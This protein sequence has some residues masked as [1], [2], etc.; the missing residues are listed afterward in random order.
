MKYDNPETFFGIAFF[1]LFEIPGLEVNYHFI[2]GTSSSFILRTL[3]SICFLIFIPI[4]AER[5]GRSSFFRHKDAQNPHAHTHT[6]TTCSLVIYPTQLLITNAYMYC[7]PLPLPQIMI[8]L[9]PPMII[10]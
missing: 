1:L 4:I 6:H 2:V 10:N 5:H 9:L 7:S 8:I 3:S